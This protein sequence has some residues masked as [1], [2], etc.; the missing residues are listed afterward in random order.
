MN[1]RPQS[2]SWPSLPS[3]RR[4]GARAGRRA[5]TVGGW[6]CMAPHAGLAHLL[7][8]GKWEQ[9]GT[10]G[11]RLNR[12][13]AL[14]SVPSQDPAGRQRGQEVPL[15]ALPVPALGSLPAL[16]LAAAAAAAEPGREQPPV[17]A[18]SG[19]P[20]LFPSLSGG[21]SLP[22]CVGSCRSAGVGEQEGA[23]AGQ[24]GRLGCGLPL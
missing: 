3:P 8:V 24:R 10:F 22:A 21:F 2:C 4:H 11:N 9:E 16:P 7:A 18:A 14:G 1:T 12:S 23:G 19:P 6:L 13:I 5:S 17:P 20:S 15:P